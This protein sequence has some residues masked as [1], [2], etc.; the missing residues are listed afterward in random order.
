MI[1][2]KALQMLFEKAGATMLGKAGDNKFFYSTPE[3]KVQFCDQPSLNTNRTAGDIEDLIAFCERYEYQYIGVNPAGVIGKKDSTNGS[4]SIFYPF[5]ITEEFKLLDSWKFGKELTQSELLRVM[6]TDLADRV[7]AEHVQAIRKLKWT[8]TEI[9][10]ND[11]QRTKSNI[12]KQLERQITGIDGLPEYLV[13]LSDYIY[14]SF[15][16][17]SGSIRVLIDPNFNNQTFRVQSLKK[18]LDALKDAEIVA[19]FEYVKNNLPA[20]SNINVWLCD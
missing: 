11:N 13:L 10:D 14:E 3:G 4:D 12:G 16:R 1:E 9:T 6:R 19:T 2:A 20:T 8:A 18:D 5:T 7:T 15:T 17:G